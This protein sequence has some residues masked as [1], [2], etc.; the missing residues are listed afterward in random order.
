MRENHSGFVDLV[1]P[2]RSG[3]LT[4]TPGR[5]RAGRPG[6]DLNS[7]LGH[8][9]SSAGLKLN[10]CRCA[11]DARRRDTSDVESA[12][13]NETHFIRRMARQAADCKGSRRLQVISRKNS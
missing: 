10:P 1:Q 7:L 6:S 2:G 9:L 13:N 4:P 5:P 8:L 11:I 12:T 3:R